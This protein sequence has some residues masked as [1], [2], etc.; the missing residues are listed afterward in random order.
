MSAWHMQEFDTLVAAYLRE[1]VRFTHARDIVP[2]LPLPHFG[3]RH[4][5]REVWQLPRN[6]TERGSGSHEHM[7]FRISDG[8]GEDPLGH[9]S[10]CWFGVCHSLADHVHY[11]GR[12]MYH[13][14]SE[15]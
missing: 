11:L 3:Y 2:S 6:E 4:F 9:N 13:N 8:S 5:S 1:S 15:C 12:H 7:H 14:P 10:A